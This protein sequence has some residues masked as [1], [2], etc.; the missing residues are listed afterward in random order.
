MGEDWDHQKYKRSKE[1]PQRLYPLAWPAVLRFPWN[2]QLQ[3]PEL[4]E[5]SPNTVRANVRH[6]PEV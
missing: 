5:K 2:T 3:A 4:P 1:G 6:F